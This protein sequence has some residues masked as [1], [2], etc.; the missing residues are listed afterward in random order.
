[1]TSKTIDQPDEQLFEKIAALIAD[2]RRKVMA[3]VNLAMVHTYFE[4]GRMIVEDEQQGNE[5]AAYGK[6]VLKELSLRLSKEFG[7]G[8]S[9]EN[10]DRMRFFYK[11]YSLSNSST[12]LT[13]LQGK[14]ERGKQETPSRIFELSWSHYIRL[15]RIDNPDERRFY[16]LE[17]AQ[18]NW[19][20][21]ELQRQFDSA[22]Y[23]RLALSR[24]KDQVKELAQKGQQIQRPQDVIKDPYVLEFLGLKEAAAYSE[25]TLEHR[26][27]DELQHFLLE[28]GK[29]FAFVGRQVRF[30]FDD[31][32]FRVDLV[33]YN[34]FLRS[35][36]LLDLKIGE[37]S[38]QDLGQMQMYV[39]YYDRFVKTEDEN[40]TIGIILCKE[41]NNA[42]VE[43]T[44]PKENNQIF[45]SKY[46]TFLPSKEE[47]KAVLNDAVEEV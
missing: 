40:P 36:V 34:R 39:N 8:F 23:E 1:M 32:H 7:K 46:Q 12:A 4:I 30:S 43:I 16:E 20:L 27:I 33:F 28:L 17:S 13:N 25:S 6:A 31:K 47:L 5:R 15:M 14:D 38:H 44:L 29:G 2:A 10:L 3:T 45:A 19:S 21:K 26:I 35:F 9:V 42:L 11:T 24:N 37:V 18:N 41:K 22:L